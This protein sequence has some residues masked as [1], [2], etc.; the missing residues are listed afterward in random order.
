MTNA[1]AQ[2]DE[3][4]LFFGEKTPSLPLDNLLALQRTVSIDVRAN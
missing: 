3:Y 2:I 4:Q 1:R